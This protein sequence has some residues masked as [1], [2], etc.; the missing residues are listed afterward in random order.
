MKKEILFVCTGNT[1]R[2]P[3]AE[4]LC[5]RMLIEQ[6]MDNDYSCSSAGVYAFEGDN[7]SYEAASVVKQDGLDISNHYARILSYDIVKDAYIIFTMTE[8]HKRMVL[9][10]YSEARDKVFT[11]K[12]FAQYSK[13][14]KDIT[15]P[16]GMGEEAYAACIREIKTV[17]LK[18]LDRL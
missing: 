2:S 3:M 18:I 16:F 4:V 12:E 9:D 1:C 5:K 11:L 17:L 15:D 10:V 6:N 7:A 14:D 13:Y 8:N